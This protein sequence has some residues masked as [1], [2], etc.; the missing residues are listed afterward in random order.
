MR[1]TWKIYDNSTSVTVHSLRFIHPPSSKRYFIEFFLI[2]LY[3]HFRNAFIRLLFKGKDI[4]LSRYYY[5]WRLVNEFN[6]VTVKE[7]RITRAINVRD[8]LLKIIYSSSRYVIDTARALIGD[9]RLQGFPRLTGTRG[10]LPTM[11]RC[12]AA[13]F[14]P[15]KWSD[16]KPPTCKVWTGMQLG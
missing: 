1:A 13:W 16:G 6:G 3:I 9:H 2:R 5:D 15:M 10:I 11:M 12:T 4:N 8:D 7:F 14:D